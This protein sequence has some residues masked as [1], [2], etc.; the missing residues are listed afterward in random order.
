MLI[1]ETCSYGLK[2]ETKPKAPVLKFEVG[3]WQH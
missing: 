2:V 3:I 1:Y